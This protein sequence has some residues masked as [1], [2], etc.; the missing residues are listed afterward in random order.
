MVTKVTSFFGTK[1][2]MI[3]VLNGTRQHVFILYF[4]RNARVCHTLNFIGA[5][6]FDTR[7]FGATSDVSTGF[8]NVLSHIYGTLNLL[9]AQRIRTNAQRRRRRAHFVITQ[10]KKELAFG[11]TP[12]AKGNCLSWHGWTSLTDM[13]WTWQASPRMSLL[14]YLYCR[15][16]HGRGS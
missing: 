6:H 7:A 5:Q 12:T 10:E 9:K 2:S 4:P 1:L 16:R 13:L 15:A 3:I 14:R 8:S 11:T